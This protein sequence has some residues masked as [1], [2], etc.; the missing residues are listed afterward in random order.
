MNAAVRY[1]LMVILMVVNT[2]ASAQ[3][4]FTP[5]SS[6]YEKPLR[7]AITDETIAMLVQH[8]GLSEAQEHAVRGM[9][10]EHRA[11]FEA[12]VERSRPIIKEEER[13]V[14]ATPWGTVERLE[15]ELKREERLAKIADEQAE[16]DQRFFERVKT[17][18]TEEQ[19]ERWDA[20]IRRYERD[21][22][23]YQST[24][25]SETGIDQVALL[26]ELLQEH[27]LEPDA[28]LQDHPDV[29]EA[30]LAYE[31][32]IAPKLRALVQ[33]GI[34][35]ARRW[36]RRQAERT[37]IEG[38][39]VRGIGDFP[40]RE[41]ERAFNRWREREYTFREDLQRINREY[42]S[43]LLAVLPEDL[44]PRYGE[45]YTN[46]ALLRSGIEAEKLPARRF[47]EDA[48]ALP[49]L[50]SEQR[51]AIEALLIEYEQ[52]VN[53]LNRRVI[54]TRD[55]MVGSRYSHSPHAGGPRAK[56]AREADWEKAVANRMDAERTL[57]DAVYELLTLEQQ[58]TI[59]R[60][61]V[62][63]SQP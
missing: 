10:N 45:M 23:L 62:A 6:M 37:V 13:A 51:E 5:W 25:F 12:F 18:L 2:A 56:E 38:D 11:T 24:S 33:D 28:W 46:A 49:D 29:A 16:L 52:R 57:I 21:R 61:K 31:L 34:E 53:A 9:F 44:A 47:A 27:E 63:Q 7:S 36:D 19:L 40:S 59:D 1:L 14:R 35:Q 42:R 54:E 26:E 4:T 17:I 15:R 3:H 8:L 30:L 22:Y 50:T 58:A 55:A 20:F 41:A 32:A 43:I 48:L 60:P 39:R